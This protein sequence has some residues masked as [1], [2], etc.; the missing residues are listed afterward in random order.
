MVMGGLRVDE[1]RQGSPWT[2]MYADD[3]VICTERLEGKIY[4]GGSLPWEKGE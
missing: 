3:M 4:R 1:V 2:V